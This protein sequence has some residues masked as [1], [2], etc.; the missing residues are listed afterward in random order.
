MAVDNDEF[1]HGPMPD[2]NL[3]KPALDRYR[4]LMGIGSFMHD[5]G[6]NNN[7]GR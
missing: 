3:E 7:E 5:D 6:Q 2:Y 4:E 1:M